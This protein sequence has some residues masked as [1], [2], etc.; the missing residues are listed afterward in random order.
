VDGLVGGENVITG[1]AET[2]KNGDK[3]KLKGQTT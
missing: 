3:I 1:P 2:L